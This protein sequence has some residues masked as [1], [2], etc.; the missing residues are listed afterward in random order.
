MNYKLLHFSHLYLYAARLYAA[1]TL[2]IFCIINCNKCVKQAQRAREG[3]S[4][5]ELWIMKMTMA[6]N[7]GGGASEKR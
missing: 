2:L 7:D 3:E 5:R 1:Q 4:E 6:S